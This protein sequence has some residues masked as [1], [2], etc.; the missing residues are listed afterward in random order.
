MFLFIQC[1]CVK[2]GCVSAACTCHDSLDRQHKKVQRETT[3]EGNSKGKMKP[4]CYVRYTSTWPH[5]ETSLNCSLEHFLHLFQQYI[6][7]NCRVG[8]YRHS[9]SLCLHSLHFHVFTFYEATSW[10]T[11]WQ[12]NIYWNILRW[13]RYLLQDRHHILRTDLKSIDNTMAS[14]FHWIKRE[15]NELPNEWAHCGFALTML[16]SCRQ[17]TFQVVL[18]AFVCLRS[19]NSWHVGEI[20]VE[21]CQL[22]WAILFPALL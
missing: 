14:S 1:Y 19:T 10:S 13:V 6:F 2:L 3:A 17:S 12:H 21:R 4:L 15:V 16:L 22:P 20:P 8:I 18:F 7:K 9:W 5:P 11:F